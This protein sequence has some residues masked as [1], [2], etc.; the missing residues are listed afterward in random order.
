MQRDGAGRFPA[1]DPDRSNPARQ[2]ERIFADVFARRRVRWSHDWGSTGYSLSGL[3]S[4][5]GKLLFSGDISGNFMALDAASG[6]ILWHV[7]LNANVSNG[8][9]SYELDGSQYLVVGVG[10]SLYAFTLPRR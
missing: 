9:M 1:P 5:A 8:P 7:N 4:T 2:R 3:L 10:D 6:D